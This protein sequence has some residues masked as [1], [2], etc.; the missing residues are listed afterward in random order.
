MLMQDLTPSNSGV[1]VPEKPGRL[2]IFRKKRG[3]SFFS[4]S[5]KLGLSPFFYCQ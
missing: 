1:K 4:R 3:L 5:E 2:T